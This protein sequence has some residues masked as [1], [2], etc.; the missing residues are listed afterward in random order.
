MCARVRSKYNITSTN[1]HIYQNKVVH[2]MHQQGSTYT[3]MN[4]C[5]YRDC[6]GRVYNFLTKLYFKCLMSALSAKAFEFFF[7]IDMTTNTCCE[8]D[9]GDVPSNLTALPPTQSYYYIMELYIDERTNYSTHYLFPGPPAT[10]TYVRTTTWAD[11]TQSS[12]VASNCV[13]K[14]EKLMTFNLKRT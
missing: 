9:W 3:Y 7:L 4:V 13:V 8:A 10:D 1:I 5:T 6:Q 14:A 12:P 11:A 2:N